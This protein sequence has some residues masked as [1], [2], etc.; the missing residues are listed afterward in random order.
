MANNN[1]LLQ[2][3]SNAAY[4][5]GKSLPKQKTPRDVG[6]FSGVTNAIKGSGQTSDLFSNLGP[7]TVPYGGATKYEGSHPGVDIAG[8]IGQ[9]LNPFSGGTVVDMRTG[10]VQD[11]SNPSFGNYVIIKDSSGAKHRYSHLNKT[12][13]KVGQQVTPQD[14]IGEFGNTG[15][16]YSTSGGTG[17]HLDYRIKNAYGKYVDPSVYLK[18]L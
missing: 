7:V 1:E 3:I 9:K 4:G 10:R 15:S 18:R 6:K 2:G 17:S 16:T 5:L 8:P 12:Y 14:V 13:V 11:A